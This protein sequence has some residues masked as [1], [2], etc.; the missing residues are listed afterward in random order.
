LANQVLA[1][2]TQ[3]H[4]PRLELVHD[5]GRCGIDDLN[6]VEALERAAIAA[7]V[8]GLEQRQVR[9]LE[10]VAHLVLEP[11]LRGNGDGEL[12]PHHAFLS[13][14]A[15]SRSVWMAEPMAG[16]SRGAPILPRRP[17]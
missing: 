13:T 16:T 3:V 17:S 7:L 4:A 12:R 1:S 11:S 5:L 15:S 9:A 8:T 14:A 2:E 6:A 10:Q